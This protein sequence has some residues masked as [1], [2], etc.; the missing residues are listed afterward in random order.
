MPPPYFHQVSLSEMEIKENY[1]TT[2]TQE[3]IPEFGYL[4]HDWDDWFKS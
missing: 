4:N 1:S 3:H 2:T